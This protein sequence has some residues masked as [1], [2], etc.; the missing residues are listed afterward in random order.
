MSKVFLELSRCNIILAARFSAF[1]R[2]EN[3]QQATQTIQHLFIQ[4]LVALLYYK[5]I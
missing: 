4:K 1:G 2:F 5:Y 3:I